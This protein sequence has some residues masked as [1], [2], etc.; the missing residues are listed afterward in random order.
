MTSINPKYNGKLC[1]VRVI[2]RNNAREVYVGRLETNYTLGIVYLFTPNK[3][4]KF[5]LECV[6]YCKPIDKY[7]LI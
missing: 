3:E 6:V 4:Y 7:L 5:D 2:G 1:E